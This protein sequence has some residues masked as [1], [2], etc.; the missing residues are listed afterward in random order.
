MADSSY[1]W[2]EPLYARANGDTAQVPW[3]LPTATVY[4]TNWL[5]QNKIDGTGLAAV[6]VGCG[7]G[8]DAEA[9]AAAGFMV[10]AF[11][12]SASAIA[13]AKKRFP[14]SAVDY[15]VADVFA[16]P[17]GWLNRFDL[18]FDFRT[19]QA[20]PLSVRADVMGQI[21]ALAKPGGTVL[22]ITYLRDPEKILADGPPWP[23]SMAE[24]TH[25]E[26]CGLSIV[27]KETFR[28]PASRF[29]DRIR[30]QYQAPYP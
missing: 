15:V 21:A 14:Q 18:V 24:L 28:Q 12:V 6:V 17:A 22:V 5:A 29:A 20:L 25:F 11:D 9:L 27:H 13:W 8:D 26:D 23:L 3:A 10:T 16:L 1:D 19:I 4:L 7:L 30:I 2:F